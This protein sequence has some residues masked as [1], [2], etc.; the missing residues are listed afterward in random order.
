MSHECICSNSRIM[1]VVQMNKKKCSVKIRVLEVLKIFFVSIILVIS[2]I[3][4]DISYI[5]T[6]DS[7]R[8]DLILSNIIGFITF[9]L[10]C[11][12][13]VCRNTVPPQRNFAPPQAV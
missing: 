13:A 1:E 10:A 5:Y 9:H 2:V 4:L 11:F 12:F 3:S 8:V 6:C 7:S